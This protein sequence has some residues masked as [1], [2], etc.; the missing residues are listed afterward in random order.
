MLGRERTLRLVSRQTPVSNYNI[1]SGIGVP[2][3][4]SG[5]ASMGRAHARS[6][7]S[8]HPPKLLTSTRSELATASSHLA[9]G[10]K[11]TRGMFCHVLWFVLSW[12]QGPASLQ[13]KLNMLLTS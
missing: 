7:S 3:C 13:E 11:K 12:W 4:A 5:D 9:D 1:R 10:P 8:H 2:M 6:T